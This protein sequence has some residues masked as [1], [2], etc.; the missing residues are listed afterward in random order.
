MPAAPLLGAAVRVRTRT[1]KL[2]PIRA[3]P[4]RAAAELEFGLEIALLVDRFGG[5]DEAAAW[6]RRCRHETA[7][8]RSPGLSHEAA[9]VAALRHETALTARRMGCAQS[10]AVVQEKGK[11]LLD[12]HA[13]LHRA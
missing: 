8:P 2:A 13:M 4:R 6:L 3:R 7:G 10:T 1:R 9:K 5:L 11:E 12:H